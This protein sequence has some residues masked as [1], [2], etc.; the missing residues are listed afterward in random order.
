MKTRKCRL[1]F[2]INCLADI[3]FLYYAWDR[4]WS[5][6]GGVPLWCT[7]PLRTGCRESKYV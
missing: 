4:L 2:G 6:E 7:L 1:E 5:L 3:R